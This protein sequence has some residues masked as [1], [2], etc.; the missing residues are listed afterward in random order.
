M[1]KCIQC[2]THDVVDCID[3]CGHCKFPNKP[4]VPIKSKQTLDSAISGIFSKYEDSF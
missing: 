4:Y 3:I 2:K 1:K